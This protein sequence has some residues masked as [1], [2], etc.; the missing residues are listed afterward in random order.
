MITDVMSSTASSP[1]PD[2][3]SHAW[4]TTGK[5]RRCLP[6]AG[7]SGGTSAFSFRRLP[8]LGCKGARLVTL[9]T[10]SPELQKKGSW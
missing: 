4:P 3:T 10:V 6:L 8:F 5:A 9:V 1:D 2:A 7:T